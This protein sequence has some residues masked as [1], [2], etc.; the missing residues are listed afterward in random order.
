MRILKDLA[1]LLPAGLRVYVQCD[2]WFTSHKL[3][4][5]C[6]RLG[7][8]T[9]ARVRSN[10]TLDQKRLTTRFAAQKHRRY[11]HVQVDAADGRKRIFLVRQDKGY[12]NRVPFPV[13]VWESKRH[14]REHHPA[15]I[16][17][18]DLALSP[19]EGARRYGKRWSCEVDNWYLKQRLGLGDFRLHAYEAITKYIAVAQLAWAYVQCRTVIGARKRITPAEVVQQHR[20][21][22]TSCWLRALCQQVLVT[23]DID[24][25][26]HQYLPRGALVP[27]LPR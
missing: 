12:L 13:R 11:Y 4:K 5:C 27:V 17:C 20:D 26:L 16:I 3:L 15:Y 19:Q 23:G 21:Q 7:W 9:I 18:T 1:A 24:L 8:H 2:A 25:A 22:N 14:Y 10:R 6:H